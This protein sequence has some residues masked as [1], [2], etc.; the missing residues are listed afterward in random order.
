LAELVEQPD[1]GAAHL[2]ILF[3]EQAHQ[4]KIGG[5]VRDH[6]D[7]TNRLEGTKSVLRVILWT[8]SFKDEAG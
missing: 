4:I 5:W 7:P 1:C 3:L 2:G 6:T 8:A